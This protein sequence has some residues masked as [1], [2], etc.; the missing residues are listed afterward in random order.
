[1]LWGDPSSNRILARI[2]DRLPVKW[3]ADGIVV[4]QA[5][6]PETHA[7]ILIYPNPLNLTK[8]VVLNSG[9][10]FREAVIEQHGERR[11]TGLR[12]SSEIDH[13][14]GQ[15]DFLERWRR[16]S[17]MR[18]AEGWRPV[19]ARIKQMRFALALA[20]FL[21]VTLSARPAA[22]PRQVD[23][24]TRLRSRSVLS[25]ARCDF[26]RRRTSKIYLTE[27]PPLFGRPSGRAPPSPRCSRRTGK[28]ATRRL[29]C[30]LRIARRAAVANCL[31]SAPIWTTTSACDV[32]F[33]GNEYGTADDVRA[34]QI[35]QNADRR[36][37]G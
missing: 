13:A 28:A 26:R 33:T 23:S 30:F 29:S 18:L 12:D 22:D 36:A 21:P 24:R 32:L 8:Y 2:A 4:E 25:R 14:A 7:A 15:G 1:M 27:E 35:R 11:S 37:D 34:S 16:D 31:H 20:L 9:F 19:P 17:S 6:S 10:T 5:L 3:T